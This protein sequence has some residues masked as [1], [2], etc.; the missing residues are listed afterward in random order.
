MSSESIIESWVKRMAELLGSSVVVTSGTTT[1]GTHTAGVGRARASGDIT[2]DHRETS[3]QIKAGTDGEVGVV[4]SDKVVELDKANGV[5]TTKQTNV[6]VN[7]NGAS[8]GRSEENALPNEANKESTTLKSDV[9][10]KMDFEKK[11][12][13][14]TFSDSTERKKDDKVVSGSTSATTIKVGAEGTGIAK[15]S[16]KTERN[17]EGVAV[18][19]SRSGQVTHESAT[20]SVG[21]TKKHDDGMETSQSLSAGVDFEDKS[22][23]V[24]YEP[25]QST[26]NDPDGGDDDNKTK[27]SVAV[28]A[29]A[30]AYEGSGGEVTAGIDLAHGKWKTGMSMTLKQGW[31]ITVRCRMGQRLCLRQVYGRRGKEGRRIRQRQGVR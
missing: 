14:A 1:D 26:K 19:K 13:D 4:A 17:G 24:K 21:K 29:K 22:V 23:D 7:N 31:K 5:K 30:K 9:S 12:L 10:A 25:S 16:S 3:A 15:S 27:T 6:A 18:T 8:V 11:Q 2:G 20:G 28:S